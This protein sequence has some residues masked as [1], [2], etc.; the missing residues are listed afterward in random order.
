MKN[1]I[2]GLLA[3]F[4]CSATYGANDE[5]SKL[6][7]YQYAVYLLPDSDG[8]PTATVKELVASDFADFSIIEKVDGPPAE[9]LLLLTTVSDVK[10]SY[11]PPDMESLSY[12]GRGLSRD[13]GLA[14]QESETALVIDVGYPLTMASIAFPAALQLM[15]AVAEKHNGLIWDEATR[16]V[17]TVAAW[18]ERR[19][20]TWNEGVP[21]VQD[22]TAIHAYKNG[23]YVRAITLGMEKFGQ[24]DIVVNDFAWSNNR[25]IG[26]LI[27]LVTQTLIEGGVLDDK[28]SLAIDIQAIRNT[29]A[30]EDL[31]ASLFDNAEPALRLSFK[32]EVPDEGD[33]D[34]FLLAILFD[35]AAGASPQEQQ[36]ALLSTLFGSADAITYVDHDAQLLAAS[37]AAQ[38]KLPRLRDAFSA[39]LEPGEFIYV[40][41]PFTTADGGSEWMWVEIINWEGNTIRGLLQNDPYHVPDLKAG[42]EVTVNMD[43]IFDYIRV[44]A[45]GTREGNE[46][47]RIMQQYSQ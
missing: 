47:G 36:E 10:D 5:S 41:A 4:V 29:E 46:T 14:L 17:F 23:D 26:S 13:Q 37:E 19:I 44:R 42:A 30:R 24:P 2:V 1:I 40:K 22:H 28:L 15:A 9:P 16:E 25:A 8:D 39:G 38:K 31:L 34:N 21:N 6:A 3:V 7:I 35:S 27:N 43:E 45:D 33:P 18:R 12:K 11:A 20:D 32:P